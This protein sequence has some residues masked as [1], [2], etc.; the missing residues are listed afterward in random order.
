M[1]INHHSDQ[2]RRRLIFGGN[3]ILGILIVWAMVVLVNYAAGRLSHQPW[4][5]TR[6]GQFSISPRTVKLLKSLPDDI[7]ITALYRVSEDLDKAARMQ[8]EEQKRQIEDLLRRYASVSDKVHYQVLDPLKD[9]VAKTRFIQ[10][11]KIKYADEA[12]KHKEIVDAFKELDPKILNL[13]DTERNELQKLAESNEKVNKNQNIV[14][15]YYRF[16]KD[17]SQAQ[18]AVEDVSELIS[19][20]DVPH[21]SEAVAVIQK[22]YEDVKKDLEAAGEFLPADGMKIEELSDQTKKLFAESK[23]RYQGLSEEIGKALEKFVDLPK[24]ELEEIYNQVKPKNAKTVILQVANQPKSRVLNFSD[25]WTMAQQKASDPSQSTYDFNGEAAISSAMLALTAKDKA[26]VIF[27]HAGDPNPVKPTFN[28]MRMSQAPYNVAKGK[29]EEAN[30]VV[31]SWDLLRSG[32]APNIPNVTRKIYVV[33]PS[34]P[35]K[36]QAGA[37]S[38]GGYDTPQIEIVEK[39]VDQGERVMFLVNFQPTFMGKPYPFAELFK[40]KFG[41][42][43]EAEK[44]VLEGVK[45]RD[46]MIPNNQIA[47]DRYADHEITRPIQSLN[48]TFIWAVPMRVDEKLPEGVSVTPLITIE[49]DSGN[50]WAESNIVMVLQRGWAEKDDQDLSP[51]FCLGLAVDESKNKGKVVIFGNELFATDG[52]ANQVQYVMTAQGLGARYVNPGNLELLANTTFW[53]NDNANL[54]SVGPRKSDVARICNISENGVMAWKVFLCGLWPL[55]ALVCGG[56]VYL[57]RRK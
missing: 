5:V 16:T 7:T 45:V 25:I 34:V 51:P 47:I 39:L 24:L 13:L 21:Y 36:S 27:V 19:G 28:M 18:T 1:A 23:D 14:A 55:A 42:N 41:V 50:I 20:E 15:I 33:V 4:D 44:L 11:L 38:V 17:H 46:Q 3:V 29:L 6:S 52:V 12:T 32:E 26:A 40:K 54:I 49:P 10:E 30:F 22:L 2:I 9:T 57:F 8:A 43:L 56:I 35:Q 31:E 48:S 53:L 37:P